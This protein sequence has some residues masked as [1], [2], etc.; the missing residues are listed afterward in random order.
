MKYHLK[1]TAEASDLLSA[2]AKWYAETSRSLD[3]AAA[4]YDGFIE[5]IDSLEQNPFAGALSPESKD[6]A[7]EIREIHYGSGRRP[8]HRAIYRIKGNV[9]EVLTIRHLAQQ[10]LTLSDLP[11]K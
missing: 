9:V 1:I 4:W 8:T 7:I 3:I 11:L 2:A 6:L 10:P 5:R